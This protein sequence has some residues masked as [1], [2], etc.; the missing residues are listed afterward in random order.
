MSQANTLE[1]VQKRNPFCSA[2]DATSTI[3][4]LVLLEPRLEFSENN[5][6]IWTADTLHRQVISNNGTIGYVVF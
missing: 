4:W 6:N 5:A 1:N 2:H 3:N